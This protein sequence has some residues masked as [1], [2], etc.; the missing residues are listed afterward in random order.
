MAKLTKL[1][2][3]EEKDFQQ[4]IKKTGWYQEFVKEYGESPD[5][6]IEEYDYRQAWKSGVVPER[7]PYDKN[8]YHWPSTD[9]S[10]KMI[11]SASHPTAWQEQYMQMTGENPDAAGVTKEQFEALLV[12]PRGA[13]RPML[14]GIT[15]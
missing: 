3:S 2:P 7:D 13:Q 6:D 9:P 8:R 1:T 15:R 5:L 4:W 12:N 11:K 10:G 14:Q